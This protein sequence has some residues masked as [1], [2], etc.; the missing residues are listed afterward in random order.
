MLGF[1]TF[2]IC[3]GL[4][5]Y[6]KPWLVKYTYVVNIKRSDPANVFLKT[7]IYNS[8]IHKSK[9]HFDSNFK[10]YVSQLRN[11]LPSELKISKH[12]SGTVLRPI[13]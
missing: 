6:L 9:F 7:V 4:P 8:I 3:T 12:L 10:V 5:G 13:Y 1:K 11:Y 2:N